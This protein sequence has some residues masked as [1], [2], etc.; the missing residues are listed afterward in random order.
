VIVP[1][2]LR[3]PETIDT[4]LKAAETGHLLLSTLHT[5]DAQA[6]IMR[7]ISMFPPEEQEGVR[8]RL[9]ESLYAVISQRL[10][11]RADGNGRVVACEV[12]IVTPTIQELILQQRIAEIRDFIAEGREQYGMQTFDQH[13]ADIVTQGIVTFDVAL[14]ASTRPADFQL[15]MNMFQQSG[16]DMLTDDLVASGGNSQRG[17]GK[18]GRKR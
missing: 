16:D 15:K 5:P 1:G 18:G 6:T 11:P 7:M 17:V 4:G 9:A 12:M 13:L 14:T 10:L 8:I 2:E 3:D